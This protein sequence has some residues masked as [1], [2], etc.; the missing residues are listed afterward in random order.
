MKRRSLPAIAL[1]LQ[2]SISAVV[3]TANGFETSDLR[4]QIP[5]L[6]SQNSDFRSQ[7][8]D[9]KFEISND[10]SQTQPQAL[11]TP[12]QPATQLPTPQQPA[13]QPPANAQQS[14]P[15]QQPATQ[16]PSTP[17]QPEPDDDVVKISTK[18]VQVDVVVTDKSGKPV[19]DLKPEEVQIFED[20]RSQKITHFSYVVADSSSPENPLS[21]W[22]SLPRPRLLH[23]RS[24][25]GPSKF[26]ARLR[27]LLTISD[28]RFKAF[29]TCVAL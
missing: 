28:C 20:G 10:R 18:L 25:F 26:D 9:L 13:A 11:P 16:Q 5:D 27:W 12:Q 14:V 1:V 19:T 3:Q 15:A 6:K 29:I 2:L 24:L 22:T 21:P 17:Q 23:R 4:F 8:S 7:I